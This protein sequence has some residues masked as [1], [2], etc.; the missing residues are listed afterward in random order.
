[1]NKVGKFIVIESNDEAMKNAV[2]DELFRRLHD[3]D[4]FFKRMKDV[5]EVVEKFE[6]ISKGQFGRDLD[7]MTS[8]MFAEA[9]LLE[10]VSSFNDFG[11]G[12]LALTGKNVI[13]DQYDA[14]IYVNI[15]PGDNGLNT[16]FHGV[17]NQVLKEL[18]PSI[19]ILL[20][21]TRL[22][23]TKAESTRYIRRLDRYHKFYSRLEKK[24]NNISI[25]HVSDENFDEACSHVE[26]IIKETIFA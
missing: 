17:N 9:A 4:I 7:W 16:L 12:K 11:L 14:S 21:A 8:F 5:N 25:V 18:N 2:V 26:R 10:T 22:D 6:T 20:A 24:S 13:I 15:V 19:R 1:M 23:L 3:Y